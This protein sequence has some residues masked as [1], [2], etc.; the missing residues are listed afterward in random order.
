MKDRRREAER[1]GHRAEALAAWYLRLKGYSILNRRVRVRGG[2]VDLVARK[3]RT[4]IFVEVKARVDA[5]SGDAALAGHH[6]RRVGQAAAA[7]WPRYADIADGYRI[8][9]VVIMPGRWPVHLVGLD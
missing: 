5:I 1:R 4:I 6:L 7:L 8:D 9:A 3:G 2:E